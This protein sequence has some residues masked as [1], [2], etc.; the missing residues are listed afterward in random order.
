MLF[1]FAIGDW[2]SAIGYRL[3]R[4]AVR[5]S[6]TLLGQDIGNTSAIIVNVQ[7]C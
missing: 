4:G 7:F 3:A 6:V 1:L 5:T 2:L